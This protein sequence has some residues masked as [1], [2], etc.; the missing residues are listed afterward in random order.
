MRELLPPPV[1]IP[2]HGI[3][4]LA[5]NSS[6]G[7]SASA[8]CAGGAL[9]AAAAILGSLVGTWLCPLIPEERFRWIL[10][11]L[12]TILAVRLLVLGIIDVAADE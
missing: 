2:V 1:V 5:S 11:A 4:Q 3:A 10:K 9:V 8:T 6:R 7:S 12:L